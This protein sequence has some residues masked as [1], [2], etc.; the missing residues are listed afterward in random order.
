VDDEAMVAFCRTQHTRLVGVLAY[1]VGDRFVAEELA[2]ETLIRVCQHWPKVR[3]MAAPEAWAHRVAQNLATSWVRRRI[4]ERRATRR[5]QAH[6]VPQ[7]VEATHD[8]VAVRSEIEQLPLRQRTALVLRYYADLPAAQV[9]VVM[10][11]TEGTVRALTHQAIT[12]LR[13]RGQLTGLQ[14]VNGA[15]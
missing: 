5:V 3:D 11:C 15:I 1:S 4:A 7:V 13:E 14:E 9:G 12:S 8:V 10:G 6:P 2:Q